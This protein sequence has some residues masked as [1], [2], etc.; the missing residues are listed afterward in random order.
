[1]KT[2]TLEEVKDDLFTSNQ[3]GKYEKELKDEIAKTLKNHKKFL[4]MV[5]I[6]A[7]K[8]GEAVF[9]VLQEIEYDHPNCI[10][11]SDAESAVDYCDEVLR[12]DPR[13]IG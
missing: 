11:A 12:I 13:F 5:D 8:D 1:M 6:E 7:T 10:V 4:L 9:Y 3:R 2:Y